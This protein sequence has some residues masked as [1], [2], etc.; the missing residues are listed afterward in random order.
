M[1]YEFS[2][3]HVGFGF[4]EAAFESQPFLKR[5]LGKVSLDGVIRGFASLRF[6]YREIKMAEIEEAS[7]TIQQERPDYYADEFDCVPAAALDD[8]ENEVATYIGRAEPSLPLMRRIGNSIR[9]GNT[10]V[11]KE[12]VVHVW[13]AGI[14]PT[15]HYQPHSPGFVAESEE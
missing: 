5:V 10:I 6:F 8:L 2:G 4:E 15:S 13:A 11:L 14:T 12:G 9:G 7:K 3:T 1:A